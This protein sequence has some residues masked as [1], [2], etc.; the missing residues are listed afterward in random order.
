M[1]VL[2]LHPLPG[3]FLSALSS[4]VTRRK[5][6]AHHSHSAKNNENDAL[7]GV[8]IFLKSCIWHGNSPFLCG[9]VLVI[10]TA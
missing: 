7:H 3:L 4:E 6:E 1:G 2:R 8:I 10:S 9:P 5:Y